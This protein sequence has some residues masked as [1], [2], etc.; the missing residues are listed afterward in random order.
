MLIVRN[1]LYVIKKN[2]CLGGNLDK[3]N[4]AWNWGE[5]KQSTA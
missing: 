5:F 3:G 1:K 2:I 4:G